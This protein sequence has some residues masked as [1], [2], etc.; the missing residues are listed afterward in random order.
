MDKSY[1]LRENMDPPMPSL[2]DS[3][4]QASEQ[5]YSLFKDAPNPH[6]PA[7]QPLETLSSIIDDDLFFESLVLPDIP[8]R[9]KRK[10]EKLIIDEIYSIPR[11]EM[12]SRTNNIK[13]MTRVN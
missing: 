7:E 3:N 2:D 1:D 10:H 11:S 6:V 5:T 13:I 12:Q 9:P 4:I 8:T